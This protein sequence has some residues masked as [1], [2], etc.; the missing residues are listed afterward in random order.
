MEFR[1]KQIKQLFICNYCFNSISNFINYIILLLFIPF[2]R[3]MSDS[4]SS[5]RPIR[6]FVNQSVVC[7]GWTPLN[8]IFIFIMYIFFLVC[9]CVCVVV[10]AVVVFSRFVGIICNVDIFLKD[11]F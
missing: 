10:V 4:T 8:S 11:T 7:L 5:V 6:P 2:K 9:V 3:Q 1:G